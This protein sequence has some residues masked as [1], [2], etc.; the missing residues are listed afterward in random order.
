MNRAKWCFSRRSLS[1]GEKRWPESFVFSCRRGQIWHKSNLAERK[2]NL[3]A[4]EI[5]TEMSLF[6]RAR[7][8][9]HG[10]QNG[11]NPD[12]ASKK[13]IKEKLPLYAFLS[14]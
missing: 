3:Q 12:G 1:V 11:K 7:D 6:P 2:M 13:K 8:A 9:T 10:V 4:G 14:V 5:K